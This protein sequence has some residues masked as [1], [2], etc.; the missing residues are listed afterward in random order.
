MITPNNRW[1]GVIL[2]AI[3]VASGS[4]VFWYQR[5][6]IDIR[7]GKSRPH[8]VRSDDWVFLR[9][10]VS[11]E[12]WT[13]DASC[14]L[15]LTDLKFSGETKPILEGEYISLSLANQ[16]D[17]PDR[18]RDQMLGPRSPGPIFDLAYVLHSAPDELKIP[19]LPRENGVTQFTEI[20]RRPL[21]RGEY[22]F[23]VQTNGKNCV[24]DPKEIQV[25][26]DGWP[27]L[28]VLQ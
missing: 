6:S 25:R 10:K 11:N 23:T 13:Q 8:L 22:R 7:G 15:F 14:R 16:P 4:A 24:S 17:N 9:V 12:S 20:V 26:F 2:L 19:A 21:G 1:K 28:T 5:P 3:A 27:N 18:F